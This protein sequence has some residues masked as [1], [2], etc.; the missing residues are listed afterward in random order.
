MRKVLGSIL[1]LCNFSSHK[2]VLKVNENERIFKDMK[3]YWQ[4][5]GSGA[6]G[7]GQCMMDWPWIFNII[8]H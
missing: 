5:G 2:L 6:A 7:V 4:S 1:K 8:Y 3:D